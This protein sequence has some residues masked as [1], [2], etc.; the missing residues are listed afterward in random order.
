MTQLL[1]VNFRIGHKSISYE[2]AIRI[3]EGSRFELELLKDKEVEV[4]I[5]NNVVAV[6]EITSFDG[7]DLV[8][9]KKVFSL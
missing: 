4:V 1:K 3:S 9:I 8:L 5:G 6:G 2:E 7:V